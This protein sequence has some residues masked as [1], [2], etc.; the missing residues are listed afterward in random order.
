M[1]DGPR[2]GLRVVVRGERDGSQGLLPHTVVVHEAHHPHGEPL[3]RGDEPV[4]EREGRLARHRRQGRPPA[5]ASELA[6]GQRP[7]HDHAVSQTTGDGGS[8]VTNRCGASAPTPA[9]LHVGEAQ[10]GQAESGSQARRLVAVVRVGGEAVDLPGRDAGILAGAED[11]HQGKLEFGIR[12][13]A[14][15]VVGRLP[16]AYHRHLA[17]QTPSFYR[18][19]SHVG[20]IVHRVET[21]RSVICLTSGDVRPV[22]L[23]YIASGRTAPWPRRTRRTRQRQSSAR[24]FERSEPGSVW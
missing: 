1:H 8:G 3:G 23:V 16:N 5:E 9:P 24:F 4:G 11:R 20:R 14:V 13:L 22:R 17:A 12:G 10:L 19:I 6:L 15:L 21:R 2:I 18:R 7:E